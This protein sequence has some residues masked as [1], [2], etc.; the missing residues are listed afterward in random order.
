M[1]PR[2]KCVV[3]K[4]KILCSN[5]RISRL[6]KLR[7]CIPRMRA[8]GVRSPSMPRR[9]PTVT[10]GLPHCRWMTMEQI[11]TDIAKPD[12]NPN[13][14]ASPCPAHKSIHGHGCRSK[15]KPTGYSDIQ[16]IHRFTYYVHH[17]NN[18][19]PF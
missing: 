7:L 18:I 6:L 17:H 14:S 10:D 13:L 12:P 5:L 4:F 8:P 3:L 9:R 19:G 15:F 1:D 16:D 11:W 2:P